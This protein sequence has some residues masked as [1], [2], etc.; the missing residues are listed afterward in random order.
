MAQTQAL[1]LLQQRLAQKTTLTGPAP[2]HKKNFRRILTR[3]ISRPLGVGALSAAVFVGFLFD[4][5]PALSRVEHT[6]QAISDANQ[7]GKLGA[8]METMY[9]WLLGHRRRIPAAVV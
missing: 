8:D 6:E 1:D 9:V 2:I 3:N 4:L 7:I 5:L